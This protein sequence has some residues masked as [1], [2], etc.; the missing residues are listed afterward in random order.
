MPIEGVALIRV[1][2]AGQADESR[3]GIPAQ[4]EAVH[5]ICQTWSITVA[6]EPHFE[7]VDVS[8]ASV[9]MSQDYQRFLQAVAR[10]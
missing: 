4:R 2:T 9:L 7:L 3:A 5:R 6:K 8:G 10:Q 1:S